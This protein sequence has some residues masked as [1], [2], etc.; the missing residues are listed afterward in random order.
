MDAEVSVQIGAEHGE[1]NPEQV[2]YRQQYPLRGYGLRN[3]LPQP[4]QHQSFASYLMV[5]LH[6][7]GEVPGGARGPLR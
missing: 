6:R 5:S 4:A 3:P 1:R 2:T 7:S